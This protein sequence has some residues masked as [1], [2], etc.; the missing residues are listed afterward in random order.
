MEKDDEYKEMANGKEN[1]LLTGY[2]FCH[3]HAR[4][5]Y[6]FTAGR[7][8][9]QK[10]WRFASARDNR[11]AMLW[12]ASRARNVLT[13]PD[14]YSQAFDPSR[15]RCEQVTFFIKP[16]TWRTQDQVPRHLCHLGTEFCGQ[17]VSFHMLLNTI[18]TGG[19]KKSLLFAMNRCSG[20]CMPR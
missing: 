15:F 4:G 2:A 12:E 9:Q 16:T 10:A 13:R 6:W 17:G 3:Y 11:L 18:E 19:S 20:T 5:H 8:D 7:P 14:H 1:I